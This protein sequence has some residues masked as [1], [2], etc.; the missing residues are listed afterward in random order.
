M[1]TRPGNMRY[2]IK[3]AKNGDYISTKVLMRY[4]E[5]AR[6]TGNVNN[7]ELEFWDCLQAALSDVARW[8]Q[9]HAETAAQRDRLRKAAEMAL[10]YIDANIMGE[11][12]CKKYDLPFPGQCGDQY[13]ATIAALRTALK[14]QAVEAPSAP[15]APR[16]EPCPNCGKQCEHWQYGDEPCLKPPQPVA[17][18]LTRADA[19]AEKVQM[20]RTQRN[21][22][23][24][25][26]GLANACL[27]S[28]RKEAMEE[29]VIARLSLG[30]LSREQQR[31][32]KATAMVREVMDE[33]D[34]ARAELAALKSKLPKTKDGVSVVPGM[35]VYHLDW[36][37]VI[38]KEFG[39]WESPFPNLLRSC[40]STRAAAEHAAKEKL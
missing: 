28:A 36:Q 23:D 18:P 12:F 2:W 35:T 11:D 29:R 25:N 14:P 10:D 16:P 34:S 22:V 5:L 13:D 38:T 39:H 24:V 6:G 9:A 40:Y 3:E 8:S 4:D 32:A 15:Q 30:E 33:R 7:V 26:L 31:H 27:V 20:L 17:P 37:G 1:N 21:A 19:V